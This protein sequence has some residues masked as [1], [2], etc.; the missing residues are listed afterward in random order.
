MGYF[1]H[2]TIVVSSHHSVEHARE[3]HEAA[4]RILSKYPSAWIREF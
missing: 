4:I 3:A 1:R 2:E